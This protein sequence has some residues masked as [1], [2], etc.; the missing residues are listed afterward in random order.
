MA[1]HSLA[2]ER[3][4]ELPSPLAP[5]YVGRPHTHQYVAASRVTGAVNWGPQQV[6]RLPAGACAALNKAEAGTKQRNISVAGVSNAGEGPVVKR[7]LHPCSEGVDIS[8]CHASFHGMAES[9]LTA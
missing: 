3:A 5:R 8:V 7:C 2:P 4:C 9:F 6:S 1:R